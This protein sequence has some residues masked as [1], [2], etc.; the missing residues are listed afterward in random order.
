MNI[1][2]NAVIIPESRF[3][4]F[5]RGVEDAFGFFEAQEKKRYQD[6]L[7]RY[8]EGSAYNYFRMSS[9]TE[10]YEW[11][12]FINKLVRKLF[13][14]FEYLLIFPDNRIF[15]CRKGK[16]HFLKTTAGAFTAAQD[17]EGKK[18]CS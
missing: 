5:N 6:E 8:N 18:T 11:Q 17:L 16:L 9:E 4:Q 12:D 15:G 2:K 14:K 13:E 1:P 10:A 3:M 7:N